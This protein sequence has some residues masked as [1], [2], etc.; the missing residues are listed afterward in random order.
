MKIRRESADACVLVCNHGSKKKKGTCRGRGS[1]ELI[2]GIRDE[3]RK[4]DLKSRIRVRKT[5]CLGYCKCGPSAVAYPDGRVFTSVREKDAKKI[6]AEV[7]GLLRA[8]AS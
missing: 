4:R 3:I 8:P 7:E 2:R 6:V 5:Q 1:A